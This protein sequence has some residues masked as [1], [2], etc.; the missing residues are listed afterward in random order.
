MVRTGT[1]AKRRAVSAFF[2]IIAVSG[3]VGRFVGEGGPPLK[4]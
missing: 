4:L 3:F 2:G 1:G